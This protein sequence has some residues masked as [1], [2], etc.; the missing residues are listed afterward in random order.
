MGVAGE[1]T[2]IGRS[3]RDVSFR[4]ADEGWVVGDGGW[5]RYTTDGGLTWWNMDHPSGYSLQTVAAAAPGVAYIGGPNGLILRYDASPASAAIVAAS[6]AATDAVGQPVPPAATPLLAAGRAPGVTRTWYVA[7]G[8]DDDNACTSPSAA[9]ASIN[10]AVTKAA[11][12]DTI[13]VAAGRYRGTGNDVAVVYRD[14]TLSGGWNAG[15]T[16]QD[17]F[18]VLD[19]EQVRRGMTVKSTASATVQ[20]FVI[21]NGRAGDVGGL[22]NYGDLVLQECA[23]RANVGS[24]GGILNRMGTLTLRDSS[25]TAHWL[26]GDAA[27]G[28][29]N[30]AALNIDN[31]TLSGN[32]IGWGGAAVFSCAGVVTISSSTVTDNFVDDT[33]WAGALMLFGGSGSLRNSIVSGNSSDCRGRWGSAGYNLIGNVTGCAFVS[34]PSDL[35]GA[36]ARLGD[37]VRAGDGPGYHPL[38]PGSPAID[39]AN[40]AGC[41]D[42]AGN[43][44]SFDQRGAM[45]PTDGDGDGQ[46]ICDIGAYEVSRTI[47]LPLILR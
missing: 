47:H 19:G 31:S 27:S 12:G 46:T 10:A 29:S 32:H 40:P 16:A 3:Y 8:G 17:G 11:D 9:C 20:R 1:V 43:L 4:T 2:H 39:A 6:R 26:G 42:S 13:R 36:D 28:I 41:F 33:E 38:L 35:I 15:F 44:L 45:R 14:V 22:R 18:S 34:Q 5:I 24:A 23:V 37:L 7:P 25:V 21:E 30:Q